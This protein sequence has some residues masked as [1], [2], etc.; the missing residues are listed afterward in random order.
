MTDNR[1]EF[2]AAAAIVDDYASRLLNVPALQPVKHHLHIVAERLRLARS[3]PESAASPSLNLLE[4]R[5]RINDAEEKLFDAS[6]TTSAPVVQ[7]LR[8]A[9]R[10]VE[11]LLQQPSPPAPESAEAPKL[12]RG[13]FEAWYKHK[14]DS[15]ADFQIG[16]EYEDDRVYSGWAAWREQH[17]RFTASTHPAPQSPAK[18]E[19]DDPIVQVSGFGVANTSRTQC[20]YM[21]VG[22]TRTGKVVM[23]TGDQQWCDVSPRACH[24]AAEVK[25]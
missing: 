20:D 2:E 1:K 18:D 14:V 10:C 16:R 17:R 11:A 19:D 13:D 4:I 12:C 24:A 5:Q 22:L 8:A 25:P 23:S 3:A 15:N 9:R 21:L 6:F 7:D